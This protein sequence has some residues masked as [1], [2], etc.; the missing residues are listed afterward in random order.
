LKHVTVS[1]A[2]KLADWAARIACP[3]FLEYDDGKK[4]CFPEH[5]ARLRNLFEIKDFTSADSAAK[6][7]NK[8]ILPLIADY[9]DG[10]M[11]VPLR[12]AYWLCMAAMSIERGNM[13][14]TDYGSEGIRDIIDYM[15]MPVKV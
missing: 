15:K 12:A 7:M 14:P 10:M 6:T 2:Y 8:E 11:T 1:E 5:A 9:R 4:P 3:A 13:L